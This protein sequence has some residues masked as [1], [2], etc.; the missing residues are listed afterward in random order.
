MP[1]LALQETV[2]TICPD[3]EISSFL[4]WFM[5]NRVMTVVN[6]SEQHNQAVLRGTRHEHVLLEFVAT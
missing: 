6:E 2:L 1:L 3:H 4:T 5:L